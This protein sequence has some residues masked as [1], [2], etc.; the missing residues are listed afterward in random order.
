[1]ALQSTAAILIVVLDEA[2]TKLTSGGSDILCECVSPTV[3]HG[4]WSSFPAALDLRLAQILTV[5]G[6]DKANNVKLLTRNC[7]FFFNVVADNLDETKFD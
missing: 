7:D 5:V 2:V 1:M 3:G 4:T 6:S